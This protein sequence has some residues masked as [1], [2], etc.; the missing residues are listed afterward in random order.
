MVRHGADLVLCQHSHCIGCYE[1]FEGGHILYG[2]GNFHFV[3]DE[4]AG[5]GLERKMWNTG[6]LVCLDL[7]TELKVE[8]IPTQSY[9]NGVRLCPD[10]EKEE[11]LSELYERSLCLKNGEYVKKFEEFC[12]TVEG[13][14]SFIPE[15]IRELFSHYLDCEAH[16]D[17]WRVLYKTANHSNEIKDTKQVNS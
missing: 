11:I 7:D 12:K 16:S 14:Y 5:E 9:G 13:V 2:Q 10:D 8:L 17:V 4:W 15:N 3:H 6:L 1:E